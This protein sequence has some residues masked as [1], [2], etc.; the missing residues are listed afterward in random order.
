MFINV[1][2]AFDV[3]CAA[4]GLLLLSP[5][6]LLVAL[7]IKAEDGGT[8]FYAQP[9]VGLGFRRFR[10]LKFRSMVSGTEGKGLITAANDDRVT[11]VGRFI[12]KYKLDELPQLVNVLRGDMDLVGSRPEVE[13]YVEMFRR[14]YSELLQVRPGITDPASIIFRDEQQELASG[15]VEGEYVSRIL[16]KK[17]E[18]SLWYMRRRT[19][20]SDLGILIRTVL[21]RDVGAEDSTTP[22]EEPTPRNR[23]ST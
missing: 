1:R 13:R 22:H 7:A 5:V 16:P 15:N 9:R 11:G 21:G 23:A 14:E 18:L 19:F 17:L 2:R 12:R 4:F 20:F 8:V 6:L 3:S 10:L